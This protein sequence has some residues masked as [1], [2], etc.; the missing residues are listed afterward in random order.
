M[1]DKRET[2]VSLPSILLLM[3]KLPNLKLAFSITGKKTKAPPKTPILTNWSLK[4]SSLFQALRYSGN[5]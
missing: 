1:L 5:N 3:T 2:A 4:I